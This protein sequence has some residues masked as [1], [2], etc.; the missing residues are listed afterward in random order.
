[1]KT[2]RTIDLKKVNQ[3]DFFYRNQDGN[4]LRISTTRK[5]VHG[6]PFEP[7]TLAMPHIDYP[8]ENCLE[9]ATRLGILDKWIPICILKFTKYDIVEYKGQ[10]AIDMKNSYNAHIYGK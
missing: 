9:R 2:Q 10:K 1:M 4:I 3:C 7:H 6:I 8:L 5:T